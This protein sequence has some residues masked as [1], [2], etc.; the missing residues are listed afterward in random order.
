MKI[1][2]GSLGL[3]MRRIRKLHPLLRV[4]YQGL[5]TGKTMDEIDQDMKEVLKK[6][7]CDG[8]C[9]RMDSS[10]CERNK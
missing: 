8:G 6:G 4:Y 3:A 1:Q 9:C 2:L 10:S 7:D 5:G